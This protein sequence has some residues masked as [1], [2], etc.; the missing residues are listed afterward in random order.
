MD[1]PIAHQAPNEQAIR[2]WNDARV[3]DVHAQQT[4]AAAKEAKAKES[5]GGRA[6]SQEALLKRREREERRAAAAQLKALAEGED[7]GEGSTAPVALTPALEKMSTASAQAYSVTV[8]ASSDGY[9]WYSPEGA[10]Y[11]TIASAKKAGIWIYP[12]NLHE[13]A[14]C[15]VFRDLWEK[16]CFMGGGIK[17]G[18][19][20]LV[21]P[22]MCHCFTPPTCVVGTACNLL[23]SQATHYDIIRI[24]QRRLLIHQ[25]QRCG[26]WKL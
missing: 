26:L 2:H 6:M 11:D 4:E 13:R 22:G 20:F 14:K 21:Y 10:T 17:F 23:C 24:L 12:G 3:K 18:G 19:D 5:V 15:G 9:E 7:Q 8:E 16:G 1:D 25:R